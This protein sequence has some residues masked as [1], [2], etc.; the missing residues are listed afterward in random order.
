MT[1]RI[2]L[3]T[4]LM[5]FAF[6]GVQAQD[7]AFSETSYTDEMTKDPEQNKMWKMGQTKYSAKPKSAWELGV[8]VGHLFIDG[9][10]DRTL[11]GGYGLGLHL[12]KSIHYVFSIRADL[13][14]GK[15]TGLDP[16]PWRADRPSING[17]TVLNQGGGLREWG[18]DDEDYV[19]EYREYLG[20]EGWFPSHQT[21]Y[22][23]GALQGVINIGNLLFHKDRNKWNWYM[24]LGVGLSTHSTKLDLLDGNN[25]PYLDL[26]TRSGFTGAKF[27]T[28]SGRSEIKDALNE[29]YDGEYETNGFKKQGIF[30][31][32]DD[33]NIHVV[34]TGSMGISRK[35]SRRINLGVEHQLM[36]TDNDYLDG[37]KFRT[38]LDATNNVD[39][40]HYT[41]IRLGINIGNLD[42]VTEPLY[43]LNPLDATMNDIAELK[44]RPILDLTD[45][46]GDGIIDMMDQELDT[47]AGCPVDTRGVTLDSDGDGYADCKDKEPYSPP[48]LEVDEEG[49]V[50]NK[51]LREDDVNTIINNKTVVIMEEVDRKF[52]N[53]SDC[54]KWFLPMIHFDL[55]RFNIKPEFYGQL[56]HIA[57][58]M[59][60]CPDICVAAIGHTD[61]RNSN[62]YNRVLS[63]NRANAAVDYLV[64]SYGIDRSRFKLMYGGEDSPMMGG[65]SAKSEAVHYMNRRVEFR[66][67]DG[68]DFDMDR[69]E[70]PNA[71]KGDRGSN[72]SGSN[73]SG[74]KNSGY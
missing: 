52:A 45:E 31:I 33:T 27:D 71:G 51:Y 6:V 4:I 42:K 13:F 7:D 22:A 17:G 70:G 74:N 18:P 8:H 15:A 3:L 49:V 57:N 41:N 20:T 65:A 47:P 59:K 29:I 53:F 60:M 38:G 23:Y 63:Y 21:T 28:K 1:K 43:W 62:D 58:V 11:P 61:A 16:Q 14:Y 12:R 30:R 68:A 54:G 19:N 32:G 37:I 26:V 69:P 44:Q 55:D 39:L 24:A 35:L 67:C 72:K 48:G 50:I 56:H 25:Q 40:L 5:A 73:Y 64:T 10:V 66:I 2:Y 46:D 36:V 34:W 9:D